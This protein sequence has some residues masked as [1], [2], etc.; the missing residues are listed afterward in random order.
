M[1]KS[2]ILFFDN[3]RLGSLQAKLILSSSKVRPTFFFTFQERFWCDASEKS[4]EGWFRINESQ[5]EK[6]TR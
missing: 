4:S 1:S 3:Y 6:F 2:E 5:Q